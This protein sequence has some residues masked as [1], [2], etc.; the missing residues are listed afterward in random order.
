[1]DALLLSSNLTLVIE[2]I[3]IYYSLPAGSIYAFGQFCR[4]V[5]P[6]IAQTYVREMHFEN[7]WWNAISLSFVSSGIFDDAM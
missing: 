5:K 7:F 2:L 4:V 6:L 3:E 1:M